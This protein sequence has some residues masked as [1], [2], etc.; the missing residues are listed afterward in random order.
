MC[1]DVIDHQKELWSSII[2][3]PYFITSFAF[4]SSTRLR[5]LVCIKTSD[6]RRLFVSLPQHEHPHTSYSDVERYQMDPPEFDRVDYEPYSYSV[7][8]L[9]CGGYFMGEA[10][11]WNP[12]MRQHV[13]LPEPAE[14]RLKSYF[15][16]YDPVEDK[17][18]VF[19]IASSS[20]NDPL[21]F[22]L[23][24][25]ESWRVIK[26][27]PK[28]Y[29]PRWPMGHRGVCINGHAYYEAIVLVSFDVKYEKFRIIRK[30][31]DPKL[32]PL[33]LNYQGKLAWVCEDRDEKKLTSSLRFWIL[34]DEEKQEW[35]LRVVLMPFQIWPR[36]DPIWR[37]YLSLEGVT[38]DTGEFI[39]VEAEFE[40]IYVIYYDPKTN[41]TRRVIYEG[42]EYE[43]FTEY[44]GSKNFKVHLYPNHIESLMSLE[45]VPRY[46][47]PINWNKYC[48][49][50]SS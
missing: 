48:Q 44:S 32:C 26:N 21:V 50:D 8:G 47:S 9:M 14:F 17:Y 23:E 7:H 29:T 46:V 42:V 30:P 45:K 31:E 36:H 49:K 41:L 39:Y 6:R 43:E 1:V 12:S 19:C 37:V 24:P 16:G 11:V 22:T 33:L 5:L 40:A 18:K 25:Q 2:T 27:S 34:E 3:R 13:T 15:L 10:V 4:M 38:Q 35:S 28:H 20:N